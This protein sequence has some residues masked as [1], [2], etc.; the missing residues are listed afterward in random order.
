MSEYELMAAR[1]EE[2]AGKIELLE[3]KLQN[4]FIG[5]IH[6][7]KD[8]TRYR[9]RLCQIQSDGKK[10]TITL[11]RKDRRIAEKAAQVTLD[12]AQLEDYR[13]EYKACI[14]YIHSFRNNNGT[15]PKNPVP[16][17]MIL[18][19]NPGFFELIN[20]GLSQRERE[21]IEWELEEYDNGKDHYPNQLNVTVTKNLTVRSKAERTIAIELKNAGLHFRYE[22]RQNIG[23]DMIPDFT[24]IHPQNGFYYY[25]EH[26]GM[27][28]MESY[29]IPFLNKLKR[30][31]SA[32]IYPDD[33][34]ILT[35][36]TQG[37][38]LDIQIVKEKI[39]RTFFS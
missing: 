27:I 24:I 17:T 11:S 23:G 19:Q 38:P 10:K 35:F 14:R 2:L 25:W 9:W 37:H 31:L 20:A 15:I 12:R 32:G 8:R 7:S 5:D 13:K 33:R 21:M 30:Y 39:R 34:L 18:L 16:K 4:E 3:A 26:H 29:Q 6:V 1:A 36:E 28:D 22:W